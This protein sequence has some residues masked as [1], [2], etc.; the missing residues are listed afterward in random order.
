NMIVNGL[1]GLPLVRPATLD[2][3]S[4]DISLETASRADTPIERHLNTVQPA[5]TPV[6]VGEYDQAAA[7]LEAY[8]DV[9]GAQ[10][11]TVAAG[12]RALLISL[13]TSLSSDRARAELAQ[14]ANEVR[15]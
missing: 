9:V 3:L 10:D 7:Q 11:P 5:A 15:S 8:K 2:Q 12:E 14:V 13:S 6:T 1:R 4:S